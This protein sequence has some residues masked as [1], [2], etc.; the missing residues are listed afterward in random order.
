MVKFAGFLK[1][2]KK[3]AGV[4]MNVLSKVNDVYKE[5]KPIAKS[6]ISALPG[7][8]YI[9]QGLDFVS[10]AVDKVAPITNA[11]ID[12]SDR[13]KISQ[14]TDKS[15]R[16]IGDVSNRLVN[17]YFDVQ[18]ALS[19]KP[20]EEENKKILPKPS[21]QNLLFGNLIINLP[22]VLCGMGEVYSFV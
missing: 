9:N 21:G 22:S 20:E 17:S 5:I 10:G 2:M 14:Y 4:G 16:L 8:G 13:A 7:G 11:W 12:A 15:K 1:R 3:I 19:N 6:V 18:D